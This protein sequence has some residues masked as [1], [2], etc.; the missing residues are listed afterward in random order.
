MREGEKPNN[1]I[2]LP[3]AFMFNEC[4]ADLFSICLQI[5][6][7]S[8]QS[9]YCWLPVPRRAVVGGGRRRVKTARKGKLKVSC[10]HKSSLTLIH[11]IPVD[12]SKPFAFHF[13]VPSLVN[14][15]L[16]VTSELGQQGGYLSRNEGRPAG[17]EA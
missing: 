8:G 11:L 15:A 12:A 5:F 2:N 14:F 3:P 4:G 17:R 6:Q 16:V 1:E 13:Q 9:V 7:G 10:L